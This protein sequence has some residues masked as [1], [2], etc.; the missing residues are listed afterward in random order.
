MDWIDNKLTS[1]MCVRELAS[2]YNHLAKSVE[3]SP[4]YDEGD[5][6][7]YANLWVA[8]VLFE[9][10]EGILSQTQLKIVSETKDRCHVLLEIFDLF[11]DTPSHLLSSDRVEV[12]G[13]DGEGSQQYISWNWQN[14]IDIDRDALEEEESALVAMANTPIPANS[15]EIRWQSLQTRMREIWGEKEYDKCFELLKS[16]SQPL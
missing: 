7:K 10:S 3:S 9:K 14:T 12:A 4:T 16:T 11:T 1:P 6:V 15:M 2:F 5:A 13:V 8:C